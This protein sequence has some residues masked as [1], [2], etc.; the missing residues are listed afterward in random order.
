MKNLKI[1]ILE[2]FKISA[3]IYKD[4]Y[5]YTSDK[6]L[7]KDVQE[8]VTEYLVKTYNFNEKDFTY[9]QYNKKLTKDEPICVNIQ[10]FHYELPDIWQD[11]DLKYMDSKASK[12]IL[13]GI[14]DYLELKGI[15]LY[16]K[17]KDD[18]TFHNWWYDGVRFGY[19]YGGGVDRNQIQIRL[20][21]I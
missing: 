15:N 4:K 6:K 20:A 12:K 9:S 1:Y 3:D 10:L 21:D 7:Y 13:D 8:L 2:K 19:E 17:G 16:I 18:E 11:N 5:T 14:K